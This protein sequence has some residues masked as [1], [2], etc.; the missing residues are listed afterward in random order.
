MPADRRHRALKKLWTPF[1]SAQKYTTVIDRVLR[2]HV[3]LMAEE[4]DALAASGAS[5]NLEALVERRTF[6]A[7]AELAFGA[8]LDSSQ[9]SFFLR[10]LLVSDGRS[11]DSLR[12]LR[13]YI[14]QSNHSHSRLHVF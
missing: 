8:L 1:M 14:P 4:M 9:G 5:F 13:I 2:R 10:R 11:D 3:H 12:H 6:D 7:F